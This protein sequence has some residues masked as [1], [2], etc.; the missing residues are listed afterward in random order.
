MKRFFHPPITLP[1]KNILLSLLMLLSTFGAAQQVIKGQVT[2]AVLLPEPNGKW[3]TDFSLMQNVGGTDA[4]Y[5][6]FSEPTEQGPFTLKYTGGWTCQTGCAFDGNFAAWYSPTALPNGCFVYTAELSGYY[7]A[8]G[9]QHW[10]VPA[11]YSQTLCDVRG[12]IRWAGG[13]FSV[14]VTP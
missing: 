7:V 2:V 6:G 9:R 1:M 8:G 10:N 11:F 4:N 3:S 5:F 12:I 13:D 14:L